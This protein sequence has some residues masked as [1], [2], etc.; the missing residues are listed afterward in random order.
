MKE[1]IFAVL[2]GL[3]ISVA[4]WI[5]KALNYWRNRGVPYIPALPIVGNLKDAVLMKKNGFVV[6]D[7]LYNDKATKDFDYVGINL[8]TNPAIMIRS[9]EII[10]RI[11]ISDFAEFCNRFSAG[12]PQ[13]D[14]LGAHNI[15]TLKNPKWKV[16]R[17]KLSPF[18]S[19]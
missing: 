14:P 7:Q 17:G 12:D 10:K 11:C 5:F 4:W 18:F 19:G 15:F 6:F 2:I 9:P 8:F 1:Y 3:S 16:M 13:T